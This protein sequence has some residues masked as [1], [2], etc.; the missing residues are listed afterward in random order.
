M[1]TLEG[2][3]RQNTD[4]PLEKFKLTMLESGKELVG[5]SV[6]HSGGFVQIET[7]EGKIPVYCLKLTRELQALLVKYQEVW[8][9]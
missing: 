8:D 6:T 5:Y 1:A 9:V 4:N 2:V 3:V 7:E